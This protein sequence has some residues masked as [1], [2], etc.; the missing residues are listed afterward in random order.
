M[1]LR[2]FGLILFLA[3]VG[4]KAG[5]SLGGVLDATMLPSFA[6]GALVSIVAASSCVVIGHLVFKI[7]LG[8]VVGIMAGQQ[9]QPAVL[10]F[11]V[12]KTGRETP[13]AGYAAVYPLAMI[14]K[15]LLAQ[16]LLHT[17]G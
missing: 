1:T 16:L 3:A 17:S 2:Q 5:G 6:L 11:A 8:V 4:L 10:A 9:T 12:E 13:N 7:P 14:A 15:I